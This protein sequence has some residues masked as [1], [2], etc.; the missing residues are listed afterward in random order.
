MSRIGKQPIVIPDK[1]EVNVSEG[2]ILVKGPHG[3]L[4]REFR[5]ADV[6]I[7]VV[8][9]EVSVV[10]KRSTKISRSLWGTYASH[11]KNMIS[12]VNKPF[13]KKLVVEGIGYR[14][15]VSGMNIVLS[16]GYSHQVTLPIP[17]GITVS[18]EKNEI[19]VTGSDKE[20]VGEFTA[21]VRAVRKPEPYKGKGIRYID[22]VVRRKQGKRAVA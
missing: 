9:K 20:V 22:E 13:V 4:S 2:K 3:A 18:V 14:V 21:K 8:D 19:T 17:E 6:E 11:I 16:V 12:G 10:P 5:T 7:N 15:E 1:T